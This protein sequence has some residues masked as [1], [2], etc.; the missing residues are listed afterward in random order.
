MAAIIAFVTSYKMDDPYPG[1]GKIH[2]QLNEARE[3]NKTKAEIEED[4]DETQSQ[5]RKFPN[6]QMN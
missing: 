3:Y 4:L 2:R 6:Y 5:L 1:Y